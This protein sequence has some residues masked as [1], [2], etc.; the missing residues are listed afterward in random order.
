MLDI[1]LL[2]Y[3]K[4]LDTVVRD[5]ITYVKDPIRKKE[6]QLLPEELIRQCIVQY[7]IQELQY[8]INFIQVERQIKILDSIR[9]YDIVVY[10]RNIEPFLLVECKSHKVP[11]NQNTLDQIARYNLTINAPYL[12][13]SNGKESYACEIDFELGDYKFI[14]DLPAF[15]DT[16]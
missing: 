14:I 8:P 7:L 13:V 12:M 10:N 3:H 16:K 1:Q 11:V 9:R 15:P 2:Q 5:G 4:D 6:I